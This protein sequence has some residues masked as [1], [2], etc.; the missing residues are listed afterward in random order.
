MHLKV[1]LP[2]RSADEQRQGPLHGYAGKKEQQVNYPGACVYG[3][4]SMAA[5]AGLTLE[6]YWEQ[7][8]EACYLREDNPVQ[9][10]TQVQAEIETIKDK[11]DALPIEKLF[12]KGDAVDLNIQIGDNRKWLSGGGKIFPALKFHLPNWRG[13]NAISVLT[14][15]C[16]IRV[17]ALP[18]YP[19][20][21]RRVVITSSATENED[22]LQEM[23]VQ[24]KCGIKWVNFH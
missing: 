3:T 22:A 2:R 10:W 20:L 24:E 6:E 4:P 8:I 7:I 21:Q 13:T 16:I 12:I 1:C 19:N 9:K 14:S 18:V 15:H 17:N 5:E 11:L 23:I